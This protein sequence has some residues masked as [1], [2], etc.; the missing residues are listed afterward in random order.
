MGKKQADEVLA[1]LVPLAAAALQWAVWPEALLWLFLEQ[2]QR[3]PDQLCSNKLA[4]EPVADLANSFSRRT[5]SALTRR[6]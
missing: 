3:T 1:P 4:W 2:L 5:Q 6:R